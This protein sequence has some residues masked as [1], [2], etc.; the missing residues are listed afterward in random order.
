MV[1]FKGVHFEKDVILACVR[2]YLGYPLSDRQLEE[3]MHERGVSVDH[4]T[5]NAG[6]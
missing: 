2:W 3:L 4:A 1:R 6:S 5:I